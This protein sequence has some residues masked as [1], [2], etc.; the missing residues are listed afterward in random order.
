MFKINIADSKE[1]NP[2][3]YL[4]LEMKPYYVL[5]YLE[6]VVNA[7]RTRDK[8]LINLNE[9]KLV[10]K[11]NIAYSAI[12]KSLHLFFNKNPFAHQLFMLIETL[13]LKKEYIQQL[14]RLDF[15]EISCNHTEDTQEISHIKDIL[16]QGDKNLFTNRNQERSLS[17]MQIGKRLINEFFHLLI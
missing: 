9:L 1:I 15:A 6:H 4:L 10:L 12:G 16:D 5:K 3:S 2:N 7:K 14:F 13:K 11:D 8:D 17:T